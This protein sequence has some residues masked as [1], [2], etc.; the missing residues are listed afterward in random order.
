M[1]FTQPRS[2]LQLNC[3]N[4]LSVR[5]KG[6]MKPNNKKRKLSETDDNTKSKRFKDGK[7]FNLFVIFW[8]YC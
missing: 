2:H 3:E 8:C 7:Y 6:N 1:Q 5:Q 4:L